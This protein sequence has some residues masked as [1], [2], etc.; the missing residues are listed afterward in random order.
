MVLP[1]NSMFSMP[2]ELSA[3]EEE[4]HPRSGAGSYREFIADREELMRHKWLM[5]EKAGQDV[6][7]EAALLDWVT[8]HRAVFHKHRA[9]R[10]GE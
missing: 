5:S 10:R 7:F 2:P 4:S 1:P 9:G 3:S 8:H 6:G